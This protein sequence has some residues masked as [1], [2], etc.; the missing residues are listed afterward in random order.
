MLV[1]SCGSN[2]TRYTVSIDPT[3]G[4]R[5]TDV[6]LGGNYG[7]VPTH[8]KRGNLG[9]G[10]GGGLLG[11]ILPGFNYRD[12][13]VRSF[14]EAYGGGQPSWIQVNDQGLTIMGPVD[15]STRQEITG[16]SINRGIRNISTLVGWLG[17]MNTVEAIDL[18]NEVTR[19]AEIKGTTDVRLQELFTEEELAGIDADLRKALAAYEVQ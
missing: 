1:V 3:T 18:A 7:L 19:R 4:V 17:L 11:A 2:Q 10:G 13:Y 15:H 6:R 5:T 8:Q 9:D 12:D 14:D 16:N